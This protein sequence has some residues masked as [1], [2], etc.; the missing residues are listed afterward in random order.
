ML[1][2]YTA[3]N[4][5]IWKPVVGW[6][7]RYE[8][9]SCGSV[10]SGKYRLSRQKLLSQSLVQGYPVVSLSRDGYCKK[11]YVHH[12]VAISHLG[13]PPGE[14]GTKR[15]M[16]TVNH[17]DFDKTNNHVENLEWLL[18]SENYLHA[19]EGGQV[20]ILTGETNKSSKLKASDVQDIKSRLMK[21]DKPV[22]IASDYGVVK[23][24]IYAIKNGKTWAID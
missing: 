8:V 12:L 9:S 6:E 22:D 17:K 18:C 24:T 14:I 15:G 10:R 23:G 5:E 4:T 1:T 3:M 20:R 21:G 2:A 7:D 19:W 11:C 16:W 13:H